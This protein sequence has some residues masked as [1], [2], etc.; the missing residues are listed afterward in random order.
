ME[1]KIYIIGIGPGSSEYLTKKAVDTVKT[2]DYTVGSTRAIDLFD[3]VNNKIAFNVKDLL[4]KLEKGVDLAIEGNTVSIL[5]TGDPG[6]SGVLNTVL[7][8]AN[9]KNFPEEKI[10]VIPGISSLQLAAARN[11]IQW[12]NANVM[13]FHGREN[14][15]DILKVINNGK[16][17][18]ALPSK[19][20][21]DMAQFLL[22]NGVDEH[23]EVVVCERLSYDDEKI[24]RSTL[25]DIANSEFTYMCIMVIY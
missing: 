23:R 5:S 6:F 25:K 21:R 22:D 20:V 8:I 11:H 15:E 10:E 7:R 12:D 3:D 18:I 17:T 9:E 4:D 16:T 19:K 13:T 14:I 2:S 24:V 1:N